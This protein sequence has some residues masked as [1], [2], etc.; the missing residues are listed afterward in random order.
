MKKE[1]Y[2]QGSYGPLLMTAD[3]TRFVTSGQPAGVRLLDLKNTIP[4]PKGKSEEPAPEPK[5]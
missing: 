3:G 2:S 4:P 5:N 1:A